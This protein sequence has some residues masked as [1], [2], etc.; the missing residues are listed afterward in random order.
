MGHGV[1]EEEGESNSIYINSVVE[2]IEADQCNGGD[3]TCTQKSGLH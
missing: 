1:L 2:G 3:W